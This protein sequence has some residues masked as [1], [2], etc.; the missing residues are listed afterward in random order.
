MRKIKNI[1]VILTFNIA[2]QDTLSCSS[3]TPS[4]G[5]YWKTLL[6]CNKKSRNASRS[7]WSTRP[8]KTAI[9]LPW[10]SWNL[11]FSYLL[12]SSTG[13]S[14]SSE[15]ANPR[16]SW[17]SD[18]LINLCWSWEEKEVISSIFHYLTMKL[19]GIFTIKITT[20]HK[21]LE[22][23]DPELCKAK[24]MINWSSFLSKTLTFL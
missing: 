3:S 14:P 19:I 4:N 21:I 24:E 2:I 9:S 12:K 1:N 6:K 8:S 20:E 17:L 10:L 16:V 23:W 11:L 18:F 5:W 13:I 15:R 22:I 7:D